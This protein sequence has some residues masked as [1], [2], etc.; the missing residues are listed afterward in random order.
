MAIAIRTNVKCFLSVGHCLMA[1]LKASQ[2]SAHSV[3]L[4]PCNYSSVVGSGCLLPTKLT[5]KVTHGLYGDVDGDKQQEDR[6]ILA[7]KIHL[8]SGLGESDIA[9]TVF[10]FSLEKALCHRLL[11][12]H[13][14]KMSKCLCIYINLCTHI[15]GA[16]Y[17]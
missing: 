3:T 16:Y 7:D 2:L 17:I 10:V 8:T 5:L 13:L 12:C 1:K 15:Q 9:V 6:H 14:G 11:M 4:L